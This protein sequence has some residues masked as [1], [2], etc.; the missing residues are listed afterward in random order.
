MKKLI[1]LLLCLLTL[2]SFA[3]CEE[4]ENSVDD[5][6]SAEETVSNVI[7]DGYFY[8]G[9]FETVRQCVEIYISR[10]MRKEMNSDKKYVTRGNYSLRFEL[11]PHAYDNFGG[12]I[13]FNPSYSSY[14]TEVDFSN[15]E[16]FC[17]DLYVEKG[18]D[19]C[20]IRP[21]SN[22]VDYEYKVEGLVEGWNHIEFPLSQFIREVEKKD[23]NGNVVKDDDGNPV[24]VEENYSDSI[25]KI[26]INFPKADYLQIYYID[27]VRY[28]QK[29]NA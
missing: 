20:K 15:Y 12:E 17:F 1:A 22:N 4:P 11:E 10:S 26:N 3:A 24:M 29:V 18:V 21:R 7:E 23:E 8:I 27:N 9:D 19:Y 2:F 5:D 25:D 6:T 14:F 16:Y 13:T 28:K